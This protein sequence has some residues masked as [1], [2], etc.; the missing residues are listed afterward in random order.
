VAIAMLATSPA[1]AKDSDAKTAGVR[2]IVW[3]PWMVTNPRCYA[4]T[5]GAKGPASH[6]CALNTSPP[7]TAAPGYD[8]RHQR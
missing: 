4:S 6:L 1:A 5:A 8:R 2:R 3:T 7:R